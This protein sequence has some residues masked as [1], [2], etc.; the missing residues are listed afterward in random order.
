MLTERGGVIILVTGT[1]NSDEEQISLAQ[2]LSS[3]GD[4]L[5]NSDVVDSG[6][7]AFDEDGISPSLD[8]VSWENPLPTAIAR[9]GDSVKIVLNAIEDVEGVPHYC[10]FYGEASI[11]DGVF[12]LSGESIVSCSSN[13]TRPMIVSNYFLE[14]VGVSILY[15]NWSGTT[16]PPYSTR[17]VVAGE[18]IEDV[19]LAN[20]ALAPN[21][22]YSGDGQFWA[23]WFL[24]SMSSGFDLLLSRRSMTMEPV[25]GWPDEE[26]V[27]AETTDERRLSPDIFSYPDVINLG[28]D[29][30]L[31]VW[32][33]SVVGGLDNYVL[34][35]RVVFGE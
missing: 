23:S 30:V 21:S 19:L 7:L 32:E 22:V 11:V 10:L 6:V 28:D 33:E 24:G 9:E 4:P 27:V 35:R 13:L 20:P 16:L 2:R 18:E 1:R 12:S 17:A 31:Q 15:F 29:S 14:T 3:V 26:V 34:L 5:W 25:L 8:I